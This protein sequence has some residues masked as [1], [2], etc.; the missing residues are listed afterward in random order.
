MSDVR[1]H[2]T[3]LARAPQLEQY[4]TGE[5]QQQ[6]RAW[7]RRHW[8]EGVAFNRTCRITVRRWEPECGEAA[9]E[10]RPGWERTEACCAPT[11]VTPGRRGQ[12]RVPRP[13]VRR[14]TAPNH[15]DDRTKHRR[16]LERHRRSAWASGR[17]PGGFGLREYCK[18]K[19][20]GRLHREGASLSS[21]QRCGRSTIDHS[22]G[23]PRT[24]DTAGDNR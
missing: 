9:A 6:R 3:E 10:H 18:R 1:N 4:L 8:E 5:Q 19:E 22:Y 17:S 12:S 20:L 24:T 11:R 23:R 16:T 7:F 2:M 21:V 15:G 13:C 14:T